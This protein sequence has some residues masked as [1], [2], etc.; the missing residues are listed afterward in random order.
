[1]MAGFAAWTKNEGIL[2]V[3]CVSVALAVP[4]FLKPKD[5]LRRLSAF[6]A[7]AVLPLAVLLWFK[8]AVAPP[9]DITGFRKY[10]EVVQKLVSPERYAVIWH[11]FSDNFW[12]F[13]GWAISPAILFLVYV[14]LRG[15][16][17]RMLRNP[18]W[19]QGVF[20]SSAL[21][22]GYFAVYV[23][24]P[25]DLRWHLDSSLPRLY[26]HIWPSFLLLAGLVGRIDTG[27]SAG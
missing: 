11:T 21:I 10:E 13:G 8:V 26:L 4:I 12:T 27:S 16:D 1:M 7:G 25:M 17:R 15:I 2:F 5:T 20:V 9:N 14:C 24:T 18:G 6:A 19:L 23:V 22:A 3:V